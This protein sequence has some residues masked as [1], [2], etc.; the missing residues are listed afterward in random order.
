[1]DETEARRLVNRYA[2]MIVRISC[3]YLKERFDAEDICQTVFLRY[4]SEKRV[5]E[6]E[7]HEKAWIIRTAVNLCKNHLKSAF[8]R[9]TVS[10]ETAEE[11]PAA[12]EQIPELPEALKTLLE[13]YRITL[14]LYYCEGYSVREIA[15]I[16]GKRENTV[17]AWLSRGRKRLREILSEEGKGATAREG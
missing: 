17:S 12:P 5:F 3:N 9:R 15:S 4:L 7:A 13:N 10:L 1:M 8:F 11:I 2:D 6:S 14:Y 16:L